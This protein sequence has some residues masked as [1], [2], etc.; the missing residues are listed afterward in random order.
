MKEAQSIETGFHKFVVINPTGCWDWKG[1]CPKNP[2]YGQF[3]SYGK[4]YR[5]HI[6]SW[7]IFKGEIPAGRFVCHTCDNPRCSNPE[8]LFLGSNLENIQDMLSKGRHPYMAKE[9]DKNHKTKIFTKDFH[10]IMQLY[11]NGYTQSQIAKKFGVAQI[12]ISKAI[13]TAKKVGY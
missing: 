10:E 1:C 5:A 6:A 7:L 13:R 2:G 11:K 12:S 3:R 9:R 4:I 8:H